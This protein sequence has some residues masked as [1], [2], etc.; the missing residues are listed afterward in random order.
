MDNDELAQPGKKTKKTEDAPANTEQATLSLMAKMT[1]L[2]AEMQKSQLSKDTISDI[3]GP[4]SKEIGNAVGQTRWKENAEHP[5]ISAFSYPEGDIARPKPKLDRETFFNGNRENEEQLTPHEILAY[6]AITEP[7]AIRGGSWRAELKL[8]TSQ[9][10]K[11][12]L[13]VW[14]PAASVDQRMMLPSG[15]GLILHELNGGP[16]TESVMDLL[17]QI[18]NLKAMLV[19]H[20][21]TANELEAALLSS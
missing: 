19:A 17:K 7:K 8:P 15:L 4:L 18:E 11:P 12:T 5:H 1:E 20:G 13:F 16:S 2:L 21:A 10:A 6:N 3:I 9:G 14:V